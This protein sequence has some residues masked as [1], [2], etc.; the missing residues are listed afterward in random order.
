M[1]KSTLVVASLF[2]AFLM[3]AQPIADASYTD[4]NSNT[5]SIYGVLGSG[6][7]LLVAN[8]GTNCSICM[9]HASGVASVADNN[10]N[11]IQ[12]WGAMTT[13]TGGN[14]NCNAVNNW[15]S[16]YNWSNVFT[17]VD[18]NKEWFV[19]GTP[20]YHVI[21][22]LDSAVVYAGSNWNTAKQTAEN[23]ASQIIGL[24]EEELV[25]EVQLT[26]QQLVIKLNQANK[27]A[28]VSL[29]DITGQQLLNEKYNTVQAEISLALNQSLKPGIYL[30]HIVID[31]KEYVKKLML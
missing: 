7:V 30:V 4:C 5:M 18:S 22:P 15:V 16:T 9:S 13:K 28:S 2:T 17:F 12:V 11:T 8:S 23:L 6:K 10:A 1:K 25:N 26:N 29:F 14:V 3:G 24:D 27:N 31:G 21:S 20:R 19:S